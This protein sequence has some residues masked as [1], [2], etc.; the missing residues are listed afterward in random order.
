MSKTKLKSIRQMKIILQPL[1]TRRKK[2][3]FT[4]GCFD[5]LHVG[6]VR[7]L[8]RAKQMGDVLVVGLNSDRSV[9][10]IKGHQR[11]IVPEKERAEILSALECVDFVVLFDEPDPLR[12]ISALRPHILVKGADWP[13]DRIIGRDVVERIGGKVVRVPLVPGSSSTGIIE[14]ILARYGRNG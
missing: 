11:P 9:R 10:E 1:R 2:I 13:K 4:N 5:L 12:L 7:Y 8:R 14:R 6:H 3:V